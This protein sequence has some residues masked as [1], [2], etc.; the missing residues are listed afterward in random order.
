MKQL[1]N[2]LRATIACGVVLLSA[3]GTPVAV[4][5]PAA[6]TPTTRV[7]L[8]GGG[9]P[10]MCLSGEHYRFDAQPGPEG[11]SFL[12]VPVGQRL[13]LRS[14]MSYHGYNVVSTCRPAL[15]LIPKQGQPL[16]VNSGLEKSGCFIEAVRED[17][18]RETGVAIEP[19][20]GRPQC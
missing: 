9:I 12:Q 20:L 1:S 13:T 5:V 17:N 16:I 7:T 15:S 6:D 18:S 8:M 4:Y 3:C 11:T 19:S 10:F 2:T 14:V